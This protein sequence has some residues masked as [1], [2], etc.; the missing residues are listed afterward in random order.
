MAIPSGRDDKAR[1]AW[2]RA[3]RLAENLQHGDIE[4][5]AREA[6]EEIETNQ[7]EMPLSE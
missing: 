7:A 4:R 3:L 5:E 2:T 1:A 6:P